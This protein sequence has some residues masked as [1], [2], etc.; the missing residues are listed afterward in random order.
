M[1][2][3][4]HCLANGTRS[5]LGTTLIISELNSAIAIELVGTR[6]NSTATIFT[7]CCCA[8]KKMLCMHHIIPNRYI[9]ILVVV[10]TLVAPD[11]GGNRTTKHC[12]GTYL[13]P[14]VMTVRKKSKSDTRGWL[15]PVP[16]V[17]RYNWEGEFLVIFSSS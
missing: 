4:H 12:L 14:L 9:S 7:H 15:D 2:E 8:T 3:V 13:T 17:G 5:G 16:R 10:S 1:A 6:P 11:R